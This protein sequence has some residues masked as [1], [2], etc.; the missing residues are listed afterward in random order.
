MSLQAGAP[1]ARL[2]VLLLASQP[3]VTPRPALAFQRPP[4]PA[5]TLP[6][7]A[8]DA[9]PYLRSNLDIWDVVSFPFRVATLPLVGLGWATSAA[10]NVAEDARLVS[11]TRNL[12]L[13]L[14]RSGIYPAPSGLGP[15]SGPGLELGYAPPF[16]RAGPIALQMGAA[17][18][19]AGYQRYRAALTARLS[20]ALNAGPEVQ[21][22]R[23]TRLEFYGLGHGSREEDRSDYA[24]DRWSADLALQARPSSSVRLQASGGW[25]QDEVRA[26]TIPQVP[27]VQSQFVDAELAALEGRFRY[28]HGGLEAGLGAAEPPSRSVRG[29]TYGGYEYWQ[30]T[31]GTPFRFHRVRAGVGLMV[32]LGTYQRRLLART[33]ATVL[34]PVG[35]REIPFYLLAALGQGRDLRGYRNGRFHDRGAL[36]GT[37]QYQYRLWQLGGAAVEAAL[38]TDAGDVFRSPGRDI[39]LDRFRTDYGAGLRVLFGGHTAVRLDVAFG[40]EGTRLH[41]AAG[42]VMGARLP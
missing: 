20:P 34:E 28:W 35:D 16:A 2:V 5:D 9:Y 38:F 37:L 4:P 18:S 14:G 41:L 40:R 10:V 25:T 19:T 30:G 3:L 24:V 26:G 8:A 17:Y 22:W 13:T 29:W 15:G 39:R 31:A 12:M 6:R 42:P 27:S 7:P 11:R 36:L 1:T 33:T 21:F 32:P 23:Q